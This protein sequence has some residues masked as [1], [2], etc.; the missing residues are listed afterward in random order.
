MDD[1]KPKKML[2]GQHVKGQRHGEVVCYQ[3]N[4]KTIQDYEKWENGKRI[5]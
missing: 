2:E 5:Y 1:K 4:G 3:Y